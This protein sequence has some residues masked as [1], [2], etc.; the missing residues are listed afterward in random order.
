VVTRVGRRG[1]NYLVADFGQIH[2][3]GR[4]RP[5]VGDDEEV[6]ENGAQLPGV[7]DQTV[8]LVVALLMQLDAK[9]VQELRDFT[10]KL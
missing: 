10:P 1:G 8:D 7:P 9:T 3:G 6:F 4:L 5:L 2:Q